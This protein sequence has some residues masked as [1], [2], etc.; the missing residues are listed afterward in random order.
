MSVTRKIDD[1]GRIVIPSEIRKAAGMENGAPVVIDH[2]GNV[3]TIYPEKP[4]SN[5]A[6]DREIFDDKRIQEIIYA[7]SQFSEYELEIMRKL[8]AMFLASKTGK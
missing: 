8:S 4:T 5:H 7:L 2:S 1:V 6:V 3:V